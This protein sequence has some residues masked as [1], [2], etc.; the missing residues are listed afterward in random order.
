MPRI[1]PL[2]TAI[3]LIVV[4]GL[5]HG[6]WSNRFGLSQGLREA[7]EAIPTPDEPLLTGNWKAK[8][9]EIPD[10]HLVIGGIEGYMSRTFYN[11][12]TGQHFDV[13]LVCGTPGHIAAHTPDICLGG[14]GYEMRK[15]SKVEVKGVDPAAEF[16][17]AHFENDQGI[18][19][20]HMRIFWGWSTDGASWKASD[21]PRMDYVLKPALYKLYVSRPMVGGDEPLETEPIQEFLKILMPE[22]RK[23][24]TR[25]SGVANS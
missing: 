8:P 19:K 15:R 11:E 25:N 18:T 10:Q 2:V 13:L 21:K 12:R 23:Q 5:I 20:K 22:L 1:L 14:E 16:W 24:L 17:A 7:L 9:W 4:S 6:W 3:V